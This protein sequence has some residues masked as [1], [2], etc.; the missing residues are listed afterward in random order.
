MSLRELKKEK[1][2]KAISDMATQLF[3]ERGYHEVTTAEIALKA[4]VSVPTLFK[5]F[6]TKESLVFDEDLETEAKLI[7]SVTDRKAGKTVLD[8]LL[9]FGLSNVDALQDNEKLHFAD[10]MKLIDDTPELSVYARLMWTRYEKSLAA[11][12]RKETGNKVGTLEA[13]A[14]ARF[15]LDSYHRALAA[16]QP[17]AS[18]KRLFKLLQDG[19]QE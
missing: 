11:T 10:M 9:D 19:W 18:L 13:D 3:M 8:S 2:R 1:T 14:I 4:E 7:R 5:Y 17:K 16:P 12:I 15:A 6:P